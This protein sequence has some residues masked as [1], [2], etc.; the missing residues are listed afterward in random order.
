[1][2]KAT[3]YQVVDWDSNFEG[4]KSRTYDHKSAC[5]MPTKH[6]LGYKRIVRRKNGAAIF[7]A[8]CALIQTLSRHH[9]PREGYCTDTGRISGKPYSEEDLAILTDIP[10]AYFRELFQVA[11]MHDVGWLRIPDGYQTDTKYPLNSDSDSDSDSDYVCSDRSEN[12]REPPHRRVKFDY[13][14]GQFSGIEPSDMAVLTE[15]YPAV[16]HDAEIQKARAWLLANP[17]KRKKNVWG[18]LTRW[19]NSTQERSGNREI[20]RTTRQQVSQQAA[21]RCTLS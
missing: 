3:L 1:M 12:G 5:Q 6:G 2:S 20:G 11:T 17:T 8:W 13:A 18:F 16:N 9:R 21:E 10:A 14:S 15:A 4:A 7:G 19:M